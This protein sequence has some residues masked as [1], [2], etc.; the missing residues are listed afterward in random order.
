MF[1]SINGYHGA[2]SGGNGGRGSGGDPS[3]DGVIGIGIGIDHRGCGD[4]Y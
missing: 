4:C 1:S 3:A 2:D